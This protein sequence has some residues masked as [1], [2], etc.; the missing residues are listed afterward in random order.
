VELEQDAVDLGNVIGTCER[1]V[2]LA[3]ERRQQT[4]VVSA[5]AELPPVK[6][7]ARAIRRAL[8]T[9]LENAIKYTPDG[10]TITV[11]ATAR[12]GESAG[13]ERIEGVAIEVSDTGRGIGPDDLPHIFD[14]FYRG[15]PPANPD[16]LDTS[17]GRPPVEVSGVG[18]GLYLAKRIISA[19]D[20]RIDVESELNKRTRVTVFLPRWHAREAPDGMREGHAVNRG[21]EG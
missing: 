11:S 18:L 7:D 17:D 6:G 15:K 9:I 16:P 21:H 20:G 10:G 2:R 4:L 14:K 19:L 12:D 5:A 8:C 1:G 13:G 3:A